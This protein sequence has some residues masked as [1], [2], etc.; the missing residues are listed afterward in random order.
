MGNSFKV[1]FIGLMGFDAQLSDQAG[2]SGITYFV[3]TQSFVGVTVI[4][5]AVCLFPPV[6][7]ILRGFTFMGLRCLFR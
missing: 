3:L 4:W 7:A 5:L 2:D 1:D 6:A